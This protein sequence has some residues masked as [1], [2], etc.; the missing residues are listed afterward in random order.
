MI[1]VKFEEYRDDNA[2]I[3]YD[4]DEERALREE[5]AEQG[6]DKT[7]RKKAQRVGKFGRFNLNRKL[8]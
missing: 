5:M 4:I 3:I 6:I 7:S 8:S 2:E 1:S